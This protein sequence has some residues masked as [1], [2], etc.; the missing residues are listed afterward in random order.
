MSEG[1]DSG[2]AKGTRS[3]A[4]TGTGSRRP[5]SG[6]RRVRLTQEQRSEAMRRRVLDAAVR[7]LGD[8]GYAGFRT[9][10]VAAVAGVSRGA[11][12]HHFPTKNALVLAALR[13]AFERAALR[14]RLR[15]HRVGSVDDAVDALLADSRDFYF[16]D[17]FL[18]AVDLAGLAGRDSPDAAEIRALSRESRLPLEAAWTSAL[19]EAGVPAD[20]AEDLLWLTTSIVRGLAVRR[21]LK[22][23][24]ARF[25]RLFALWREMVATFLER[26]V[27]GSV[28]REAVARAQTPA[29][30]ITPASAAA[31][32]RRDHPFRRPRSPAR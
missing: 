29:A 16:S 4:A 2:T 13:H 11:Q 25:A 32:A 22:D 31:R 8:K 3:R 24:P 1:S 20:R 15:A 10:E 23:E 12:T 19:E 30:S 18:I 27:A 7:V 5:S 9:A 26:E 6:S 21:L 17:L 14:G 28:A